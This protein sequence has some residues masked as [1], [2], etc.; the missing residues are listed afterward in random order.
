MVEKG[1]VYNNNDDK[2]A[3]YRGR[4]TGI[5]LDSDIIKKTD[6]L[7]GDVP[8]SR[9]I[10]EALREHNKRVIIIKQKLDELEKGIE[11]NELRFRK[12]AS[13][14]NSPLVGRQEESS[15]DHVGVVFSSRRPQ[16]N[17]PQ[18]PTE[19]NT[20][21]TDVVADAATDSA[22]PAKEDAVPVS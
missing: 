8:R 10:N 20:E 18:N 1:N 19:A 2:N 6:E 3:R 16:D 5:I 13:L 7:R 14:Q 15:A 11:K 22:E 17:S 12:N 4:M 9:Y 21:D